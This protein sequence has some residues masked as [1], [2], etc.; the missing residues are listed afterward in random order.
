LITNFL[1][2]KCFQNWCMCKDRMFFHASCIY[3]ILGPSLCISHI[4]NGYF[5]AGRNAWMK[6]HARMVS[7]LRNFGR[8]WLA[9]KKKHK[10]LL[11]EYKN[12]KRSNK[13]A[14]D[15]S[16]EC[17]YYEQMD[18]WNSHR[19]NVVHQLPPIAMK[20]PHPEQSSEDTHQNS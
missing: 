13:L 11:S 20:A 6:L 2:S 1:H 3:A 4:S 18:M 15:D 16:R 17:A 7:T 12:D 19:A 8:S 5:C 10:V 14:G 9:C